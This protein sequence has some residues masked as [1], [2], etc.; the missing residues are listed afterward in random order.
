VHGAS[1]IVPAIV[2]RW[3]P[4]ISS[5]GIATFVI[6]VY[7]GRDIHNNPAEQAQLSALAMMADSYRALAMLAK[8]ER[9]DP[10]RVAIMGFSKGSVAALYSGMERFRT[11]GWPK[12]MAAQ[13]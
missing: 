11:A 3:V 10:K 7:S 9:I 12:A 4:V 2:D 1:G 5:L 8:H 6:D 13:S